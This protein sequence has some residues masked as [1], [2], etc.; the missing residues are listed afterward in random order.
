MI[1]SRGAWTFVTVWTLAMCLPLFAADDAAEPLPIAPPLPAIERL[2]LQPASLTLQDGRDSRQVLVWGITKDGRRFDMTDQAEFGVKQA[3]RLEIGEDRYISGKVAGKTTVTIKAA[4]KTAKLP[5]DVAGI[6]LPPVDF[7]RDIEPI[8]S[9]AGCNAGTCHGAQQGKNG[10]KLSLRGYDP[11]FDY[12]ALVEEWQGRRFNRVQPERSLMLLKATAV[13]PHEGQQVIEEGSRYYQT[14]LQWIREGVAYTESADARPTRLEV[15]PTHVTLDLPGRT[16]H[17]IVLAHYADGT[18]RDVTREAVLTSNRDEVAKLTGSR[19]T[20][21][22]R[23][24][25]AI[26]IR[27]EGNYGV[28]NVTVMGDRTGFAFKPMPEHNYIDRHI[29][30]KL[31][32]V[33]TQPAALCTDAEFVRRVYV[34]LTGVPPTAAAARAFVEDKTDSATKRARLIDDLLG[35]RDYVA[36]WSNKWAD[37]LQCNTT[38]LGD[39]NVWTFR[40]W[41]RQAI[42]QNRPYDQFVHELITAQGSNHRNPAVNYML[43]LGKDKLPQNKRF[44]ENLANVDTGKITE[45]V[46][47]TFLGVR[48]NCNK[49]HDHP[50]ERWTQDQYYEFG[51]YFSHLRMKRGERDDEVIVYASFDGGEMKHPKTD[52]TVPPQVPYGSAPS[53]ED[54]LRREAF[55]AWMTSAENPLFA[56]SFANRMWSYFFGR[57]IIEPVDDIRAS[58]PAVNPPLLDALTEDFIRS[59]FDVQH[60]IRTICNSRTY[61]LSIVANKWNEDDQINFSRFYPRRLSAEQMIDAIAIATGTKN[62]FSNLPEGMRSVYAPGGMVEGSDFL[63]LFG[64]PNRESACECERTSNISLAHALNLINGPV[65]SG[66]VVEPD[67]AIVKLVKGEPDN[68]KVIEEIYYMCLSRPPTAQEVAA[69]DLGEGDKRLE[70]AQDLAWALLN[71]PAFLF[72]R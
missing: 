30:A 35:S 54:S 27:Y 51:A 22:R 64:R 49:C 50:F 66:A 14:L 17:L 4:G 41:I 10:F 70:V 44:T 52:M 53:L 46:S 32:Q 56:R 63:K 59:G 12:H 72:N 62:D 3:D 43:T 37:L 69:I 31:E 67:S 8:L 5:V 19:I 42:A 55:A 26:L 28:A 15:L 38:K 40:E 48:F 25:A 13:V 11:G 18:S 36:C 57:G 9:K 61:Q 60:L 29:N 24:E 58:N 1:R 16:Q 39:R 45:D 23:G 34:D 68:A 2:E 20:A 47:Q 71:S 33:K 7:V 65:I 6:A 21:I